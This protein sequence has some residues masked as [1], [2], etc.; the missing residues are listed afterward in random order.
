[1]SIDDLSAEELDAALHEIRRAGEAAERETW[2]FTH[3]RQR[4][5]CG[6]YA[7]STGLPCRRKV[8]PGRTRCRNHGGCSTGPST[9]DGK[10]RVGEAARARLLACRA[11]QAATPRC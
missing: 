8:E 2:K 1:V 6:A 5:R 3:G 9:V 11:Q 4:P 10:R 7:R